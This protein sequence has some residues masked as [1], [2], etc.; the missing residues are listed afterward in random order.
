MSTIN[1]QDN[2]ATNLTS[3]TSSSDTT[4]PINDIPSIAAPFYIAFDATNI[5][6]HYEVKLITSKTATNVNHSALSYDHTTAEEVRCVCPAAEMDTWSQYLGSGRTVQANVYDPASS[7]TTGDGKGYFVVPASLNGYNLTSVHA[8]VITAG[9]TGTTDIQI[10][11]VTDAV[12]MLSTKLTIDSAETGSDTAATAAVIDTTK[13]D[14]ATYDLLRF[15]ID[16]VSSTAPK[17]LILTLTFV[18]P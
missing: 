13:D 11:N 14:V 16:A 8:R 4:S 3:G 18:L 2:F 12:D 9:T 1:H 17:G 15:D 6:N 5:N 7:L 10:A